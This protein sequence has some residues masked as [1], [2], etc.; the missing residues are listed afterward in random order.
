MI[1]TNERAEYHAIKKIEFDYIF[2]NFV[3][4]FSFF[5]ILN[6]FFCELYQGI[7]PIKEGFKRRKKKGFNEKGQ[8]DV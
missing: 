1:K 6:K 8:K 3:I 2:N 5:I 7:H 4:L